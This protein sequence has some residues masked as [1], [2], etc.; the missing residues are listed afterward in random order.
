VAWTIVRWILTFALLT[1]LFSF[2][3][4]FGPNR[5][6]PRWQWVSVGGLVG[7]G[8]FLLASLGFSF[9]VAK[10][11]NYGKSY[12]ALAGV[13]I[14][15]FL[16][17]PGRHRGPARRR[18]QRRDRARGRGPG[19]ASGCSG[20]RRGTALHQQPAAAQPLT[21]T[22]PPR[23]SSRGPGWLAQRGAWPTVRSRRAA[24]REPLRL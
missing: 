18:D 5:E 4:Y 6:S 23:L 8:I 13:V 9:Y 10:F 7:T 14:L 15:I 3:Y 20:Q 16:A 1:L 2:Y 22:A 11:G 24:V 17:V 12:G 21:L 19:R